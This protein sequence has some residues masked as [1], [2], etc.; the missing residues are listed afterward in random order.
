MLTGSRRGVGYGEGT[1]EHRVVG[2]QGGFG[3]GGGGVPDDQ[4]EWSVVLRIG[5]GDGLEPD[6]AFGSEGR[7]GQAQQ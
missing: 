6:G 3:G 4:F 7:S 5:Q 2:D 1:D